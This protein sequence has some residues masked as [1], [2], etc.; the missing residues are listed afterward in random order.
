MFGSRR[1]SR[2]PQVSNNRKAMRSFTSNNKITGYVLLAVILLFLYLNGTGG[3]VGTDAP[4]SSTTK[5]DDGSGPV[6]LKGETDNGNSKVLRR[7]DKGG[8]P[9]SWKDRVLIVIL[10]GGLTSSG[11]V[12]AHTLLR[13][14]HA[15]ELYQTMKED[16]LFVTLSGGT[17]HKPNPLDARGF[18]VWEATAAARKL[19]SLGVPTEQVLEENFSLDTVGNVSYSMVEAP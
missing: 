15:Y 16:A 7:K 19:I 18:P 14:E 8:K 9:S 11:D 13:V 5:F 1:G 6:N 3:G 12:P 10:G 17:P 4:L 2:A